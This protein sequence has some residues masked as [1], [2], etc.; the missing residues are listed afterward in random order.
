M[1]ATSGDDYYASLNADTDS[2]AQEPVVKK[3]KIIKIVAKKP[4]TEVVHEE[5]ATEKPEVT[6]NT[7]P[8]SNEDESQEITQP[9]KPY[10]R[11]VAQL[12]KSDGLDLGGKLDAHPKVVFTDRQLKPLGKK[13]SESGAK[14]PLSQ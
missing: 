10:I 14:R 5:T 13:P 7:T 1:V 8:I 4:A 12:P 6:E 9:E 11:R 3:K 2:S